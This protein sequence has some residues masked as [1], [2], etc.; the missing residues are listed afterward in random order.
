MKK[1]FIVLFLLLGL[2]GGIFYLVRQLL[3]DPSR[4]PIDLPEIAR[5]LEFELE[6]VRYG[7]TRSGVKKWELST[8]KAK[9]IKGQDEIILEGVKARIYAE[10]KLESDTRIEADRGSYVVESGDMQLEGRIKII[11]RQFQ[12]TTER[13][14]YQESL[15]EILAPESLIVYSKKFKIEAARAT[16]DLARQQIHFRGGIRARIQ[17]A[18]GAFPKP[19]PLRP[20][21]KVNKPSSE[22]PSIEPVISKRSRASFKSRPKVQGK[23]LAKTP[24]FKAKPTVD[25]GKKQ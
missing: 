15:E 9:R 23:V 6:N 4:L 20:K 19:P 13:L 5:H 25:V 3:L 12:I 24:H 7:H 10:G 11:N 18:G 22:K 1:L 8:L 17:L 16:I 21:A 14:R 2:F